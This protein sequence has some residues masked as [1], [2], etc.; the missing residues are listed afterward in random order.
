MVNIQFSRTSDLGVL[1]DLITDLVGDPALERICR[2]LELPAEIV[3]Q[4]ESYILLRDS[5]NLF[6]RAAEMT[7]RRDIGLGCSDD[8]WIIARVWG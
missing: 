8:S 1:P 6:V 5:H 7:G 4:R 3:R 2:S